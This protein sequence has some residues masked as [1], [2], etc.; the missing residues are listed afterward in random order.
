MIERLMMIRW[1]DNLSLIVLLWGCGGGAIRSL[2]SS[3]SHIICR[4]AGGG[5]RKLLLRHMSIS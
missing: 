3:L 1:K 4:R 5:R 2:L